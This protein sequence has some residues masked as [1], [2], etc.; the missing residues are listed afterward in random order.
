MHLLYNINR[1]NNCQDLIGVKMVANS[2][3]IKKYI[4]DRI[5]KN[6]GETFILL[7]RKTDSNNIDQLNYNYFVNGG[8]VEILMSLAEI[9][10][11]VAK[12]LNLTFDETLEVMRNAH[13]EDRTIIR[14]RY[15]ERIEK[16]W[17]D[18]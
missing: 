9:A 13:M 3:I 6:K 17:K 15:L 4:R 2:E 18:M 5:D 7:E 10:N 14:S 8:E 11:R 12:K 16:E 1:L